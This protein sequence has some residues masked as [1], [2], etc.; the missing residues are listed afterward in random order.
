M[1]KWFSYGMIGAFALGLA[2]TLAGTADTVFK[3]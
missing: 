2:F 3:F 1:L